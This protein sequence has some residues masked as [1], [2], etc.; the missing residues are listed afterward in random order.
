MEFTINRETFLNGIQKTLGIV[1]TKSSVPIL[2]NILIRTMEGDER[3]EIMADNREIGVRGDYDASVIK[4]GQL[5]L[6]A[7]KLNELIKELEG[8]TI[9][10]A[11][12]GKRS[13]VITCNKAVCKI[14]GMDA[15]DYP[16]A[17][18]IEDCNFFTMSP[19]LLDDMSKK[20]IYAAAKDDARK[21]L[22]GVAMQ[23]I[24]IDSLPAMRLCATD[25]S[26][27]AVC[28]AENFD[29]TL[30]IPNDGVIIPRKGFMEIRKILD[31]ADGN[32]RIGFAKGSCIVEAGRVTLRVGLID[33]TY[34]DIS[35]VIPS[36][37]AEGILNLTVPRE[38]IL[39]S[40]R[41]MAVYGDACSMDINAGSI[42]FE[43]NDPNIGE[44]KDE[45]EIVDLDA[46]ITRIIKFNIRFL[47]E[48]IEALNEK[49]I[50]LS[51]YDNNGPCVVHGEF[52]KNYTALVMPLRG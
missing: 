29:D 35:R 13:C 42:H 17:M 41:R 45:I 15:S 20:V 5:T 10:I 24:Y 6:P 34:P 31:D 27:L 47:L 8:E 1:E 16:S 28:V 52:D 43:A 2:Q 7:K 39:H 50:T 48:A 36:E 9:H 4:P 3:I 32:V 30:Q 37:N 33:N 44:I 46:A 22:S 11:V 14:N 18:D 38:A 26:R 25:G 51:L 19:V 40:L 23:K 49:K 12:K 21:N